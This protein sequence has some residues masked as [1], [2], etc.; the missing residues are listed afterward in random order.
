MKHL[1]GAE[2]I[3]FV[4]GRLAF[5]RAAHTGECARCRDDAADLQEALARTAQDAVPEPSPLYWDRLSARV[6]EAVRDETPAG[7][8]Q[9]RGSWLR[10]PLAGWAAA[11]SLSLLVMISV[12]WRATLHAP[13][14]VL[15]TASDPS[16][17][18]PADSR[19]GARI[20]DAPRDDVEADAAWAIV[21]TAAEGFAW[22]DARAA[23]LNAHPGSAEG[24]A[25]E[26]SP[27]E[28]SELARLIDGE[29]ARTAGRD[30]NRRGV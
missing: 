26:L 24:I 16:P 5:E 6:A 8:D 9:T 13:A 17:A 23:G 1:S 28:L 18:P 7:G 2:L 12:V 27:A 29:I 14:P 10:S 4:E 22:D 30:P 21:R 3:D 15:I 25:L 11:A 20:A 19:S